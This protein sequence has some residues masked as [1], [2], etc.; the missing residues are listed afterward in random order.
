MGRGSNDQA[1]RDARSLLFG[2]RQARS[3]VDPESAIEA[4][5]GELAEGYTGP[6]MVLLRRYHEQIGSRPSV[7]RL[8]GE[9]TRYSIIESIPEEDRPGRRV[10]L[11]PD[12]ESPPLVFDEHEK[13]I[14]DLVDGLSSDL[15]RQLSENNDRIVID[16]DTVK[17]RLFS[18]K[19]AGALSERLISQMD[20]NE[21]L[22]WAW[23]LSDTD[24]AVAQGLRDSLA[25]SIAAGA[26][27]DSRELALT[28]RLV[29]RQSEKVTFFRSGG[30]HKTLLHLLSDDKEATLCGKDINRWSPR[31]TSRGC[32]RD[33]PADNGYKRCPKCVKAMPENFF[34]PA[35]ES[36]DF[37]LLDRNN[38]NK[39]NKKAEKAAKELLDG[40][41]HPTVADI[42][43]ASA[44]LADEM[45]VISRKALAT[46]FEKSLNNNS[47]Y[48]MSALRS[49]MGYGH[50]YKLMNKLDHDWDN[51]KVPTA[52]QFANALKTWPDGDVDD[53]EAS[54]TKLL[55]RANGKTMPKDD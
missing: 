44:Q 3:L 39:L 53:I 42:E 33:A 55:Y 21:H 38:Y 31:A 2:P 30:N 52:R 10:L 15:R 14:E 41:S 28:N 6:A 4:A 12:Q 32:W 8:L 7:D 36:E 1:L 23:R 49:M 5:I 29:E 51:F 46:R 27:A 22:S 45:R 18:G 26:E 16:K 25:A 13:E 19:A 50:A 20:D 48:P 17:E 11:R 40:D 34:D 47:S 9:V 54:I 37:S 43:S 35:E 24:A